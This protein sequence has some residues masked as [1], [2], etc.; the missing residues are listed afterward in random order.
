MFAHGNAHLWCFSPSRPPPARR[1]SRVPPAVTT[2]VSTAAIHDGRRR[3]VV[4]TIATPKATFESEEH[5]NSVV[6]GRLRLHHPVRRVAGPRCGGDAAT[7]QWC[8]QEGYSSGVRKHIWG[9]ASRWFGHPGPSAALRSLRSACW[10]V[11]LSTIKN[12]FIRVPK[13]APNW[14]NVHMRSASR[15]S[16]E[17]WSAAPRTFAEFVVLCH[18]EGSDQPLTRWCRFV[19]MDERSVVV[20]CA[21]ALRAS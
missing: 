18:V 3:G 9:A 1:P 20:R 11:C 17:S 13:S 8:S 21:S 7:D 4:K 15:T 16:H 14:P 2:P 5:A 6:G 19:L 12:S 10:A